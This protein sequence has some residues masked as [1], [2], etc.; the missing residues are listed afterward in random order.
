MGVLAEKDDVRSDN[1]TSSTD[2]DWP[3]HWFHV[4]KRS[5]CIPR[6]PCVK[7]R[8]F[9]TM[10]RL[11]MASAVLLAISALTTLSESSAA[12]PA[13]RSDADESTQEKLHD[14]M[15]KRHAIE[16][17]QQSTKKEL[18]K[19]EGE[20]M[21]PD[22]KDILGGLDDDKSTPPVEEK[23][24][25]DGPVQPDL[26]LMEHDDEADKAKDG[27]DQ[28]VD[29]RNGESEKSS[30]GG[31][32]ASAPESDEAVFLPEEGAA[33]K[34][35]SNSL[36]IFFVLSVL[37]LCIFLVHAILRAKCHYLPESLVIVFL[38]AIIGLIMRIL[39]TEGLKSVESFSPTMFFLV[40]L[41]PIIFESGYN[42]HKGETHF[43]ELC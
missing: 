31:H 34:E 8:Y 21:D 23:A 7:T 27:G 28:K 14:L 25:T 9:G 4:I 38:G 29:A 6:P 5:L 1:E 16:A 10:R 40:L 36:A 26:D 24:T 2:S 30:V 33:E 15:E 32:N 18:E 43:R 12:G 37:I 13:A 20:T 19:L 11:W 3:V 41:P 17:K 35:H 22:I 42:L 39:P